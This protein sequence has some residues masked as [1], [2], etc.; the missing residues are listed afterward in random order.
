MLSSTLWST[1]IMLNF[2]SQ[3]FTSNLDN[4]KNLSTSEFAEVYKYMFF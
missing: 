3:L 2:I 4:K 1:L